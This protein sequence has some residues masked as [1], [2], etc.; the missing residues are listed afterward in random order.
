MTP[1]SRMLVICCGTDALFGRLCDTLGLAGLKADARFA[2]IEKRNENQAAL[3]TAMEQV[4]G[5]DSAGA[6]RS[7]LEKAGIPTGLVQ[8]V[9]EA[10]E[11]AQIATRQMIVTQGKRKVPGN[12]M[13]FGAYDSSPA[14]KVSPALDQDGDALRK[15]F[16]K[17]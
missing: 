12:P 9:V 5:Q 16:G 1:W 2:T 3:K 13:K 14:A 15:E 4:L 10:E 6:W 17:S 7:K 8:T 11:M